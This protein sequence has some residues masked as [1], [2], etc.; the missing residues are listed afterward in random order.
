MFKASIFYRN[1][2]KIE[3]SL[4]IENFRIKNAPVLAQIISSASVIGLLD[5]LNGN[6]LLFTKIE[7]TFV[8]KGDKLTLKDGVA[9]GP[10]LGL[11]MNG[12]ERYGKKENI[13]DVN[14]LVSPVYIINGV[15]K[16]I[17]LIGKV[18]GGEKGEGVFGV[19]Y[20]VQ[21]NS[22]NPRVSVNPLS[23]FTPGAFRKIFSFE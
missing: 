2:N 1:K 22:S 14:G 18:F 17:P 9:V 16:A 6:G 12:F 11:T 15:V 20:K 23:I 21:G 5:N 7:G 19:S 4:D 3:G 13:I 10:S 8:Y